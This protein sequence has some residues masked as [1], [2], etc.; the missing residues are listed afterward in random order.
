MKT[1]LR[2]YDRDKFC[3]C[4][5]KANIKIWNEIQASEFNEDGRKYDK[6]KIHYCYKPVNNEKCDYFYSKSITL[7]NC[8]GCGEELDDEDVDSVGEKRPWGSTYCTEEI[9]TGYKCSKCGF[10]EEF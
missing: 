7:Q 9:L 4:C 2:E 3:T 10:E 8:A 1:E 6:S 5:G